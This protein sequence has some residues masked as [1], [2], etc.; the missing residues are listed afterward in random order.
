MAKGGSDKQ[1]LR[2][3]GGG[4]VATV[5]RNGLTIGVLI[6]DAAKVGNDSCCCNND[7]KLSFCN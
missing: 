7:S 6:E 2:F 1:W 5:S 3:K 4:G